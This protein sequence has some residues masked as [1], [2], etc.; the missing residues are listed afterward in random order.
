MRGYCDVYKWTILKR[1]SPEV[2]CLH[3]TSSRREMCTLS[4][5]NVIYQKFSHGA[6]FYTFN[7]E[8]VNVMLELSLNTL[9]GYLFSGSNIFMLSLPRVRM[10]I[11]TKR[12]C[13]F[14]RILSH[15]KANM[16]LQKLFLFVK[17]VE[18][19]I[20]CTH[21]LLDIVQLVY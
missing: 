6:A 1:T 14:L 2:K 11:L 20:R 4:V 16:M 13:P 18:K 17:M 21:T 15:M 5:S 8:N 12:S 9:D 10:R 7:G 19:T 3:L